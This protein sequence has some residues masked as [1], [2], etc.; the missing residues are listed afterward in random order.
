MIR[1]VNVK[2][3]VVVE[4]IREIE[5]PVIR[6]KIV[7]RLLTVRDIEIKEKQVIIPFKH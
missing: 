4:V 1:E 3:E 2:E 7:D 5:V 6:E